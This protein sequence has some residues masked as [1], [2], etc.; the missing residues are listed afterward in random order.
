MK[1]TLPNFFRR[2]VVCFAVLTLYT[3]SSD[4]V[5]QSIN[6]KYRIKHNASGLYLGYLGNS[7]NTAELVNLDADDPRQV[8]YFLET[9]NANNYFMKSA[10]GIYLGRDGGSNWWQADVYSTSS[11]EGFN[12]W[13]ISQVGSGSTYYIDNTSTGD[14]VSIGTDGTNVG[15]WVSVNKSDANAEWVFEPLSSNNF[16]THDG[17][18]WSNTTGPSSTDDVLLNNAVTLSADVSA[19][20]LI[21]TRNATVTVSAGTV[22]ASTVL[23]NQ[24]SLTI[25][26]GASLLTY[27]SGF[28]WGNVTIKR[29]S[30]F[31]DADLQY[32]FIGSP[33]ANF[34][35]ANLSAGYHYTYN[36]SDDSY[37]TA[38]GNM[39][40]GVGYTSAGKQS[41]VFN[42]APNNGTVN[43]ALDNSGNQFNFVA[44]PYPAAISRASFVSGNTNI[45]GA[46][47]LWDDGGSDN[48][49]R[50]NADFVTISNSGSVSAGS[51]MSGA[52]FNGNIGTAQGFLVQASTSGNVTFTESMRVSGNNADGAFFRQ[53]EDLKKFKLEVSNDD[54]RD[55]TLVAFS[56]QASASFDRM[57]DAAKH[58]A[59]DNGLAVSTTILDGSQK[60]AIQTL[61]AFTSEENETKIPLNM[62]VTSEQEY[63]FK[64]T[65][66]TL[67]EAASISLIDHK[68]SQVYDLKNAVSLVVSGTDKDRFT[69]HVTDLSSVLSAIEIDKTTSAYFNSDRLF[70][71]IEGLS[72]ETNLA[73]YGFDGRLYNQSTIEFDAR[74]NAA[75]QINGL[76]E[77]VYILR[78]GQ[79]EKSYSIKIIKQ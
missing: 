71:N 79:A 18:N 4:L 62:G 29:N 17:S 78:F 6:T 69:L 14:G 51:G 23:E 16:I 40:K 52:T 33:V 8:W 56:S 12:Q 68:L 39:V 38:T 50:T 43:V 77:G 73:I 42:G 15:E 7:D 64:I 54:L 46:I 10:S 53:A 1:K 59:N 32:S 61:R 5:A 74:G 9:E 76:R 19:N 28:S 60:L 49:Q 27:E 72:G 55:E 48:G 30:S 34:D 66:N 67:G 75:S 13:T 45:T 25:E 31:A 63:V 58:L 44:N 41:L 35:I 11:G 20:S 22:T 21:V 70:M 47:Y 24:G 36:T 26:S 37:S 3:W 57:W 65:E 2:S